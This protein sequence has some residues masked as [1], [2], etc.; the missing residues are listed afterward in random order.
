MSLNAPRQGKKNQDSDHDFMMTNVVDDRNFN[1]QL[2]M[3]K[4]NN[5]SSV[6]EEAKDST[7]KK[8]QFEDVMNNDFNLVETNLGKDD[9]GLM[10]NNQAKYQL[11]ITKVNNKLNVPSHLV[12]EVLKFTEDDLLNL[13][14][15]K[16]NLENRVLL[17]S[18]GS[19]FL[20]QPLEEFSKD[21][22]NTTPLKL[23]GIIVTG[24]GGVKR[25][26]F[27]N[28]E[29]SPTGEIFYRNGDFYN[30]DLVDEKKHGKGEF[31]EFK[32]MSRYVGN[33]KNDLKQGEAVEQY[34]DGSVYK[35][36]FFQGVCSGLGILN[37]I[38]GSYYQGEFKNG[39]IHGEGKL[40]VPGSEDYQGDFKNG[41]YHGVGT[42]KSEFG[43]LYV[44]EFKNGMM[45]GNGQFTNEKG[46]MYN[47]EFKEGVC[48]SK[49]YIQRG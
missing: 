29:L 7:E 11:K 23:V 28:L 20:A 26:T 18:D 33:F 4:M 30:G 19:T 34:K 31:I 48:I 6:E 24:R 8:A 15:S 37:H 25:G 36:T 49:N 45:D 39:V 43:A 47:G 21:L 44:G 10:N 5:L 13:F 46:V 17:L 27:E 9:Q 40:V 1:R 42:L 3:K 2:N 14:Y 12:L 22:V 41:K 16:Q 32:T 35:G 38:N